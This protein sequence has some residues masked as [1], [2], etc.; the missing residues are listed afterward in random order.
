MKKSKEQIYLKIQNNTT[1]V[2]PVVLFDV[3]GAYNAQ[4]ALANGNKYQWDLTDI[5]FDAFNFDARMLSLLAAPD[6]QSDY[7]A[8]RCE[9]PIAPG[10]PVSAADVVAAL[11]TLGVGSFLNN[12]DDTISLY[13]SSGYLFSTLSVGFAPVAIADTSIKSVVNGS[14]I[15]DEGYTTDLVGGLSRI[16][17]LNAFWNNQPIASTTKGP[18]NRCAV[19]G[20][21]FFSGAL[22]FNLQSDVEKTVYIG[23]SVATPGMFG[24]PRSALYLNNKLVYQILSDV[25]QGHCLDN[26][27]TNLGTSYNGYSTV[28]QDFFFILPVKLVP[29]IN[30]IS[31]DLRSGGAL[32]VYDNTPAEI[33]AATSLADL[34]ILYSSVDYIGQ[35]LL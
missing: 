33:A 7:D 3:V 24:N 1:V 5:L 35:Q 28:S 34:N 13:N 32:E 16:S 9:M 18:Y 6:A 17:L 26:I 29:G 8:L 15:Y 30:I 22:F 21:G 31:F 25:E 2:Q 4:N 14:L 23:S 27:N 20:A 19:I 12:G 10:D 11:N